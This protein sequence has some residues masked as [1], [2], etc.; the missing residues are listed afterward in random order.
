MV[1]KKPGQFTHIQRTPKHVI[2]CPNYSVSFLKNLSSLVLL[3]N[4]TYSC[5][6][7]LLQCML[8]A[9]LIICI[10]HQTVNFARTG[11][12]SFSVVH[13][14]GSDGEADTQETTKKCFLIGQT[15]V[16]ILDHV[17]VKLN[18]NLI[19]LVDSEEAQPAAFL[20]QGLMVS[21]FLTNSVSL[22]KGPT[23]PYFSPSAERIEGYL[24]I[25]T[26]ILTKAILFQ[27][28]SD[29]SAMLASGKKSLNINICLGLSRI[30]GARQTKKKKKKKI[31]LVCFLIIF[32]HILRSMLLLGGR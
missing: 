8:I 15:K 26:S 32:T 22:N 12:S 20:G 24:C 3:Q 4:P 1:R 5:S 18:K 9:Y 17:S 28:L 29:Y 25:Y 23:Q 30:Q 2:W 16:M 7:L 19:Q 11:M 14:Q 6:G 21:R 31:F 27:Q 13:S 10:L